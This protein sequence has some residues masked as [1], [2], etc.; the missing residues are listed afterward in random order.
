MLRAVMAVLV[1]L[2]LPPAVPI[3]VLALTL[4]ALTLWKLRLVVAVA[5]FTALVLWGMA[6]AVR[7]VMP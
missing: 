6:K 3:T 2:A 5:V 7:T 4:L 1:L